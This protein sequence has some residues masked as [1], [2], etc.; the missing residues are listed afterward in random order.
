V[1][2]LRWSPIECA[3]RGTM[4]GV[5]LSWRWGAT[6]SAGALL[7]S[8]LLASLPKPRVAES[9]HDNSRPDARPDARPD[10]GRWVHLASQASRELSVVML[11]Y[12]VWQYA[13]AISV[14]GVEDA[15]DRARWVVR[16]Q[17]AVW[18]PSER[19]IQAQA[20]P[21]D[22]LIQA[23]NGYYALV[24]VP[25]LVGTL[26][27]AFFWHRPH[28]RLLRNTVALTTLGCLVLQLIPLAPPRMLDDLGFVDTG[29]LYDQSVY[30]ALGRGMAGQLAAMPSVHVAWAAIVAWFVCIVPT[31]RWVR[32][33]GIG[34]LIL[35]L[36]AVVVTANHFWLDGIVA[37]VLQG[38]AIA[39]QRIWAR[40]GPR[41]T[42]SIGSA[43]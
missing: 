18:L 30:N 38:V 32:M 34:H 12:S 11:L 4:C 3:T 39:G 28:Y 15:V 19:W 5:W 37:V 41:S 17:S 42:A 36:W 1:G 21:Y 13:G 29:L 23:S 8:L 6:I 14:M 7:A 20:L 24:H 10:T 2:E 16:W 31:Q 9:S 27:W 25:A 22:W 33:I 26:I 43:P 35:T 40:Y